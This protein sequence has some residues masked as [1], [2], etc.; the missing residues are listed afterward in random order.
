MVHE[1]MKRLGF[2]GI[3]LCASV[4]LCVCMNVCVYHLFMACG[5]IGCIYSAD[6]KCTLYIFVPDSFRSPTLCLIWQESLADIS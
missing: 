4:S 1:G 2:F 3:F 5:F 6:T